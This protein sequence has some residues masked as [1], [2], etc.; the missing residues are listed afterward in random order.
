M[1]WYALFLVLIQ[2]WCAE[3]ALAQGA[4]PERRVGLVIGNSAYRQSPLQNPVNDAQ[5]IAATLGS[6]GFI[7]TKL[8]NASQGQMH[9]AIRQFGDSI[10]NGGV[11]LFYFAGHGVQV[12]GQNFL[13]P[14]DA[15][16]EREDEVAYKGIDANQV[17]AK[18]DSA[19]NRLNIVILDA[20]RNNPFARSFRS[21]AQGLAVMDAPVGTLLAFATA[22][23]SV[24]A[25]G[26]GKHGVYT[27]YLLRNIT[28]PGLK[29]EEVFKRTR[30]AVRQE[31]SGRQ[32]PWE[33]TSLEGDFFFV[34]PPSGTVAQ[35]GPA[36]AERVL[37][38]SLKDSRNPAEFEVYLR[39][40]P[41]GQ[42]VDLAR[43]YQASLQP[44]RPE[45]ASHR[46]GEGTI[47]A[48][49]VRPHGGFSFAREEEKDRQA[50]FAKDDA[51]RTRLNAPC[52]EPLRQRPI[53]IDITE[54]SRADG[55]VGTERSSRFA[56]LVSQNLQQAGLSTRVARTQG[57]SASLAF[58]LT[59]Q[60]SAASPDTSRHQGS[61]SIQGVVF[62]QRG[63][64]PMVRLKETSVSAE[65]ALRDPTGRI[66]TL[67]E[68]SGATF[69]GQDTSAAAR[70]L[71]KEQASDASSQLYAAF[72][73][74]GVAT[75]RPGR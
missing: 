33:N 9:D 56:Q 46:A 53:V 19:K 60:S 3:S 26:T 27:E 1:W 49:A 15:D 40:Y 66:M 54:E 37:W 58:D 4:G 28:E 61:Y 17:L 69:S 43:Q 25:D 52:P 32:I 38:N 14:V 12:R 30:F 29:I 42:F 51:I 6:L 36:D 67:V 11:G 50:R 65:L 5:A 16:I 63:A 72:C 48:P 20:C 35:A 47:T 71:T 62:A 13:I 8:E 34:A 23:G 45:V 64:N 7:V 68:V 55:L 2:L 10:K 18:M 22:P 21:S 39:R 44:E 73:G 31:T 24:A 59:G 57:K 70:T 74:V 41:T 75:G